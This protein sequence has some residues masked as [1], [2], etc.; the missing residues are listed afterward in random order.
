MNPIYLR[1]CFL[2]SF[3]LAQIPVWAFSPDTADYYTER[4]LRYEDRTYVK[5]IRTVLFSPDV[6]GL[7]EPIIKLGSENKLYLSF[8]DLD[9]DYKVYNFSIVNCNALWQVS[10]A[11]VTDYIE[12]FAQSP[13][14]EYRFSRGSIQSYTHYTASFPNFDMKIIHSGNYLLK[15]YEGNEE[16]KL[17]ITRRF[18]VYDEKSTVAMNVHAATIVAD[19]N[20]K[21]EVDFTINYNAAEIS[22][23]YAE[24]YPV[25]MQNHRWDNASFGIQPQFVRD[26]QLSYDYEDVNVFKGGNEFRAFDT[27]TLRLQTERVESISRDSTNAYQVQLLPDDKRTYK[28]YLTSPDIN[29]RFLIR[30]TDAGNTELEGEYCWVHFFL[31]W[32]YPEQSG[33]VYIFGAL[34][35]WRCQPE[36]RMI[37]NSAKKGYEGSV[38]LK[39][40]YYNY[41]YVLQKDGAAALDDVF[42]EGMHQET[43]NVYTILV[44]YRRQG[45]RM[46]ELIGIKSAVSR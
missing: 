44:Y 19:R 36:F 6:D 17:I 40:G 14:S 1:F 37:Y 9:G 33:N 25:I 41:E 20:F 30:T 13:I 34:S 21:Q 32:P 29:G 12:G 26:Q 7:V 4:I 23:P 11:S 24:I 39:Q 35:E 2:L 5:N 15:V 38:Y 42:A 8:D 10:N 43:E 27:R 16:E 22:N 46:D 28:R 45:A 18:M 31:P 3:L